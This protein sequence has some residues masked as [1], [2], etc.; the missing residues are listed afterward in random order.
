MNANLRHRRSWIALAVLG[1]AAVAGVIA[2]LAISPSGGHSRATDLE[3]E[4]DLSMQPAA[5]VT[6]Y[7]DV[8]AHRTVF[9]KVPCYCGCGRAIGHQN[10]YDCF[11]LP[12]GS[13]SDHAS[14]CTVCQDEATDVLRLSAA[15][16]SPRAIRAWIDNEYARYGPPTDTP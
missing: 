11:V 2:F 16:E 8:T 1:L 9:E 13:F 7:H 10:L 4:L 5:M 14:G 15:G 12:S 3:A 6:M